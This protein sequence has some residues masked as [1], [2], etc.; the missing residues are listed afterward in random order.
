MTSA[1]LAVALIALLPAGSLG[2]GGARL[3]HVA[4]A[5]L[6]QESAV[7]VA[8][9]SLGFAWARRGATL[10]FVAKPKATGRPIRVVDAR[11]FAPQHIVPVGDRDVCGLTFDRGDLVAVTADQPCYWPGGHFDLVRIDTRTWQAT[12][13][14][15]LPALD[16]VFPTN[17]AFGD[18]SAF[19]AYAGA[20]LDQIDLRTGAVTRR[21]PRRS[22]AKGDAVVWT[23]WL[24]R[25]QLGVG[26]AVVNVGTWRTR[27]FE[28]GARGVA[29]AGADLV[30]YGRRG[31]AVSTRSGV[32][33][34]R[35]L[36]GTDLGIVHVAGRY[37]YGGD[38]T[39]VS[40]HVVDLRTRRET[41]S[42]DANLVWSLLLP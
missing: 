42:V 21:H 10:A 37:L 40:G 19:V 30:V 2:G 8:D 33:R 5:T 31:A 18:G 39:G 34:Y 15:A 32:F 36:G 41:A 23:H 7:R 20:G 9:S 35:V 29:P 3:A 28:S 16:R 22:V 17:V 6:E 11:T 1:A 12:R 13:T 24:G 27:T 26:P 4:P 14:I 38:A 25:H